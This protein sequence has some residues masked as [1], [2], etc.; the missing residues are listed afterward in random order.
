MLVEEPD[1]EVQDAVADDA[2]AEVAGLDHAGV[3]R[4]DRDLVRVVAAHANGPAVERRV[5]VDERPQRLVPVEADAVEVGRLALVPAGRRREVDDRRHAA[6][7]RL[8]R[9]EPRRAVR[10]R[11]AACARAHRQA[12]RPPKRQPSASAAPTASRYRSREPLPERG[13]EV[14]PRQPERSGEQREQQHDRR[15]RRAR[16]RRAGPGAGSV[17]RWRAFPAVVSSSA[18]TSPRKPSAS[19][20]VA[21]PAAQS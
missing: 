14:A 16:S 2:E 12:W 4:P 6:V 1:V 21:T 17:A 19:S 13:D 3:D 9:L 10:R 5:V 7:A 20:T 11:R 15:S 8:D 18:C